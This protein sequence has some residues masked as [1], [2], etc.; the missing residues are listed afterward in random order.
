MQGLNYWKSSDKGL[1]ST[2]VLWLRRSRLNSKQ[3][4]RACCSWPSCCDSLMTRLA[5]RANSLQ[6]SA[7]QGV[8]DS[9]PGDMCDYDQYLYSGHLMTACIPGI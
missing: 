3:Q 7:M 4:I 6:G 1:T 8:S 9:S 5:T 2:G